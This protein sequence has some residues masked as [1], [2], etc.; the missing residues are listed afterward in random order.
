M[1]FWINQFNLRIVVY[2]VTIFNFNKIDYKRR[3]KQKFESP[4]IEAYYYMLFA[5]ICS[6]DY[7]WNDFNNQSSV[8]DR[9]SP[10]V[11]LRA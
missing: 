10:D 6:S 11:Y 1:W 8:Q 5:K 9:K 4:L 2:G 7:L 3:L